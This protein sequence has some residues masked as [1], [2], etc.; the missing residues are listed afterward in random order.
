MPNLWRQ[1]EALLPDTPL[2]IGTVVSVDLDTTLTVALLDGGLLRVKGSAS[3]GDRVFVREGGRGTCA[4]ARAGPHRDLTRFIPP[5]AG[6]NCD[7][8][9]GITRRYSRHPRLFPAR[10][11]SWRRPRPGILKGLRYPPAGQTSQA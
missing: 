11:C 3:P 7:A 4:G 2:M 8:T 10:R 1:F 5:A 6:S 9:T